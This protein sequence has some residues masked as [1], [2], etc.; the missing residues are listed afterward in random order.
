MSRAP[1]RSAGALG[2][3]A[4]L[5]WA[6]GAALFAYGFFHRN[7]PSVMIDALMRDFM[8]GGAILGNLSAF[9]F[10]AYA[11]LQIPV[12]LLVDR[13]GAR[14]M[15][16]LGAALC[17]AG[18]ALFAAADSLTLA[19]AGR[20]LIG[21]GAAFSFV[22]T[23]KLAT[24]WFPPERF[25]QLTG[26]TMMA[27]MI[28]GIGGQAPLAALVELTGWRA[29]LFGA[30]VAGVLLTLAIWL[31]VRDRPTAAYGAAE[32]GGA[33]RGGAGRGGA[34]R[35]GAGPAEPGGGGLVALLRGLGVVVREPQNWLV[36]LLCASM[37]APLL[38]FAGLWGVAWLMQTHGLERPEAA[39]TASLL[40]IGW[41]VG[42]PASGWLSDRSGLRRPV[43]QAG[44]LLGLVS[45]SALLYLP[46][47]P[48]L[49]RA[50]LF[51][52]SGAGLSSMAIGFAILRRVN[53][54]AVTGAAFGLLNGACVGSGAVFQPLIGG[55]LDRAWDGT[56]AAGAR[57]YSAA[58]YT[59]ALSV[60]IGFLA[61]GLAVSFLIREAPRPTAGGG[62]AGC[63][64]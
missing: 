13:W 21:T 53:T 31:I 52:A 2:G 62:A 54:P 29:A 8:V 51:L 33:G 17:A 43:M 30:A 3:R 22:G 47:L 4:W 25:A 39:G 6:L 64:R 40:L 38:A 1:A 34:G 28:G 14:R 20:L 48:A 7:A 5:V 60:L 63:R 32:R 27:G 26:L 35:G 42:S 15:L 11:G 57:V 12:G 10:Y 59:Q 61:L 58:A 44:A 37:T 56:L 16:A 50:L 46:D 9:Y 49:P 55:L 18:S 24:N 41:A 45:L 19:Y 23:L 36:A